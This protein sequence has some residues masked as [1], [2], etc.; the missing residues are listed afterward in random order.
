[1]KNLDNLPKSSDYIKFLTDL[2]GRIHASQMRAAL[3]A[4]SELISLYW[5]I[6]KSI[7]R[8]QKEKGWGNAVVEQLSSDLK[9]D[10]PGVS[11]FSRTNLFAMRQMYLFF[12]PTSEF[13]PQVVGQLPWGHIRV[14]LAKIKD[15]SIA[16]FYLKSAMEFGW[17]R[18]ILEM[19]I[20]QKL[21]ERQGKAI[22]N[23]TEALPKP[24]SDLAQQTLKDPYIFDFLTLEK[25]AQE[26]DIENQLVKQIVKFLLELGKGFA[27]IGQQYPLQVGEKEYY[28]DLLFYHIKLKCFIVIE[29][30]SG[31]FKP[32]Y[33]GKVN[34]YLSAVDDLMR[35]EK[36]NPSIGIILC[37]NKEKINV[38]YALRDINKPIGVSSF[39]FNEIPADIQTQMPTVEQIERELTTI[40][41]VDEDKKS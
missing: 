4:N 12:S 5:H 30:K 21:Y 19:Q 40:E 8:L 26:K 25:D 16:E 36:D 31:E 2:K 29:L 9:K 22:T 37:K 7:I 18:D 24:Q 35:S 34:F 17:A 39:H 14:I 11:G 33:A 10:Y 38:E 6:G 15:Q 27:F 23:F 1:M 41:N 28:L 3:A 20:E 32:E 13:V